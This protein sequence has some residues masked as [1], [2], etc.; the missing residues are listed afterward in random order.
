MDASGQTVLELLRPV[1]TGLLALLIASACGTVRDPFQASDNATA[2]VAVT[3]S[4]LNA[5]EGRPAGVVLRLSSTVSDAEALELFRVRDD[6]DATLLHTLTIDETLRVQLES[7]VEL[8]D[9]TVEPGHQYQ[10]QFS[11]TGKPGDRARTSNLI[12][13]RWRQPPPRPVDLAATV[14]FAGVVELSWE[15]IAHAGAVIFR[16]DVLDEQSQFIRVGEVDAGG[17]IFVDRQL[18]PGGVYSYRVAR[19]LTDGD[20]TQFGSAS[21]EVYASATLDEEQAEPFV[22]DDGE[23]RGERD[24]VNP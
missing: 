23:N 7:G 21:E 14:T 12:T 9:S 6:D 10:Y 17:G 18:D 16:R 20:F 1:A 24:R 13:V 3:E 2:A 8:V 22:D 5:V 4:T 11:V 15:S 19:S